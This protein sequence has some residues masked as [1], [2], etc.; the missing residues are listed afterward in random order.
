MI[1]I[2][3]NTEHFKNEWNSLSR[4]LKP[5]SNEIK[6]FIEKE[7]FNKLSN[8]EFCEGKLNNI[9]TELLTDTIL[10]KKIN[11]SIALKIFSK[12]LLNYSREEDETLQITLISILLV[13]IAEGKIKD[14]CLEVIRYSYEN[15][16]F[17][18]I[19][20]RDILYDLEILGFKPEI[21]RN[22]VV[23]KEIR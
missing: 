9:N 23:N 21:F 19:R 12:F 5:T 14:K 20:M 22:M 8:I 17:P 13:D 15:D 18:A 11:L 10:D 2:F 6:D 3:I 7:E 1:A 16:L 4:E